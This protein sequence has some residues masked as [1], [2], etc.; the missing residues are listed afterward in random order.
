MHTLQKEIETYNEF[1]PSLLDKNDGQYVLI[2]GNKLVGTFA[3]IGDALDRGYEEFGKPPFLVRKIS[4]VPE[5]LD[6]S[7]NFLMA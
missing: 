6:F 1:L 3:D 5:V 4:A 7:N 2:K